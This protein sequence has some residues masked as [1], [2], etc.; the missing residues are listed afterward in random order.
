M[1][2]AS[3]TE[4]CT[5]T[6]TKWS[7]HLRH[8]FKCYHDHVKWSGRVLGRTWH[9]WP[10]VL[11]SCCMLYLLW[12]GTVLAAAA[13]EKEKKP[14]PVDVTIT[15]PASLKKLL[16]KHMTLPAK[17]FRD[18]IDQAAYARKIRQESIEL[19]ATEGYF[20]P[21]IEFDE[22]KGNGKA[23]A[24]AYEL[25]ITP[26][27]RT[28]VAAVTIEFQGA[29]AA[30]EPAYRARAEQLRAE[31]PLTPGKVFRSARWEDAKSALLSS[32]ANR[33]FATARIV[34]SQAKVDPDT[35]QATLSI[36]I[37]SGPAFR[38][39]EL[40][41]TGL[42]RYKPDVVQNS[43][44][45][46]PGDPYRREQLLAFQAALQ[47]S[48]LFNAAAVTVKPDPMQ[49]EAVP[50]IVTL[51]E[52]QSKH[53]GAGLGYSSNNGARGEVNYRDYNFLGRA[54]NLSSLL[55]LEQ[56][57]QTFSTRVDT[58]PDAN[59]FQYSSG[60][61]VER[62]DIKNLQTFNQR[63]D[64]SR[65]RTT[66]NSILQVGVNWQ[67]E[68]RE[69]SGAP[70]T[71]NE[72]LALDLWYRYHDIDDPVNVRRGFVSEVRLG[73]GS[74]YVLSDQ[75]FIRSYLRHQHWLP[76][77]RRDTLYF[78]AEAGYTLASSRQGIPQEYLFRAGGIQSIRG[79][80]FLSL[81]VREGDAIVGGRVLATGTAEYVHWLTNDW[82]A[83]V[84]TDVGDAADSLKQF[85]LAIGYGVGARWRSPAGPFALDLARRHDTGTLR[86]HFSIAVA[87]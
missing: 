66:A 1:N 68:Q 43:V 67:R 44:P 63:V 47:N 37:D 45:F 56:K 4:V 38:Y 8:T 40:Q 85:D 78:R 70:K 81:G 55:R 26:G 87:F 16:E 17:P 52:A 9:R 49:H 12:C 2:F 72:T 64:F 25:R 82:G 46:R 23:K 19:L 3:E 24:K 18:E 35:A 57:R 73:G 30:D 74:S 27:P 15:A 62:T 51:T 22:K 80:D 29:L 48:Q 34:E 65:I 71:T 53:I 83:A 7:L 61:R 11:L 60:V 84:F 69:P 36:T 77:G 13:D 14:D 33:D 41:I 79:Y 75:D 58:L 32:I 5:G 54:W 31:W 28:R 76:I 59:H 20:T 42:E 39:G 6:S 10:A 50:V 21:E 86:L